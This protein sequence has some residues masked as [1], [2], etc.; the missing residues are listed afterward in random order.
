M[1]ELADQLSLSNGIGLSVTESWLNSD[2]VDAEACIDGFDLFRGDRSV[3][4]RGGSALYLRSNL[5]S[6]KELSFSNSV[7]DVVIVKCKKL[8][9][10]FITVYRPPDTRDSEW[11]EC[12][13]IISSTIDL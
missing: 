9:T 4:S 2:I 12:I 5:Y 6:K 13:N 10:I 1:K 7:C 11:S 3:R 8:D